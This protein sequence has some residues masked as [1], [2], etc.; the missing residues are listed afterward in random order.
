MDHFTA[1]HDSAIDASIQEDL[2]AIADRVIGSIGDVEAI[3]LLGGF[4]RG[5][6]TVVRIDERVVPYNDYDILVVR[7]RRA[8]RRVARALRA[9]SGQLAEELG[10][11]FV[12]LLPR[13]T[14]EMCEPPASQFNYDLQRSHRV[15]R[16]D[17]EIVS[18]G[19]PIRSE[20]VGRE[21]ARTAM[22]NRMVCLLEAIEMSADGSIVA[23]RDPLFA[24]YQTA[25]AL[26]SVAD[27]CLIL[28]GEYESDTAIKRERLSRLDRAGSLVPLFDQAITIKR[29]A[30]P[31]AA[32]PAG[33]WRAVCGQYVR[34]FA[35]L[36]DIDVADHDAWVRYIAGQAA[37]RGI[38]A[39]VRSTLGAIL[40]K[41]IGASSSPG[42]A[43]APLAVLLA[44][45]SGEA[46]DP[47]W[48]AHGEALY[49]VAQS[50]DPPP[51]RWERLRARAVRMW[52]RYCY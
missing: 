30:D 29:F 14:A 24:L 10:I 15:I 51:V 21:A 9:L 26:F 6:G 5:E 27:V 46:I 36:V 16:G 41:P 45:G 20:Q 17:P 12:E 34:A 22:F 13:T 39:R 8:D 35:A 44:I 7:N 32:D 2:D 3:V 52:Y 31:S 47:R 48:I 11:R 50:D 25:K 4:A 23:Q 1:H 38:R 43:V 19:R 49:G 18:R 28:S 37:G 42:A 33:Y 40:R